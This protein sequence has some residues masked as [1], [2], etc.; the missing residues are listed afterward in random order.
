M[1]KNQFFVG[2]VV[3]FFEI[4][5][6]APR[7]IRAE[8]LTPDEQLQE[9]RTQVPDLPTISFQ[10]LMGNATEWLVGFGVL[11]C[12]A[13]LVWGGLNY[14]GSLG[15]TSSAENGKKAIT[16]AILGLLIIGLSY[17]FLAVINNVVQ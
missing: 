11:L 6:L 7:S 17:A 15:S 16:Y 4:I 8:G 9:I 2:A 14:T 3:L 5:A 10:N 12:L 1:K 13:M